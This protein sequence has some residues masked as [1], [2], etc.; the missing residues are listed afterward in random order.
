MN[1]LSKRQKLGYLFS[2]LLILFFVFFPKPESLNPK[3]WKVAFIA[4]L[5]ANFWITETIPIPITAL[6]PLGFFPILGVAN[7]EE[8][9]RGFS[10]PL[11]FLFLGG[12]FLALAIEKWN[13]HKRI[14]LNVLNF[15][16]TS[17]NK[18]VY[19]FFTSTSIISMWV[20]NTSTAMMMLPIGLSITQFME[21]KNVFH[22]EKSKHHFIT[23]VLLSIAYG[24]SIG[25]I[26]TLIGTAPNI[27]MAGFV[28]QNLNIEINFLSWLKIGIPFFLF[29]LPTVPFLLLQIFP[30]SKNINSTFEKNFIRGEL[31][32]L[33]SWSLAEKYI[34]VV[35]STVVVL[36]ISQP[37]WKDMFPVVS[38][39]SVSILGALVLF[40][41]P[42][43]LST[44]KFV[45][46]WQ[47][48]KHLPWDALLLFGGGLSLATQIESSQLAKWIGVQLIFFKGLPTFLLVFFVVIAIIFLTELTSNLATT[49]TFLPV[50]TTLAQTLGEDP[51]NF[52]IPAVMAAS[53]AFMLPVATP[54]N[55]IVY[56]SGKLKIQDM[57]KMGLILN[58]VFIFFIPIVFFIF[59]NLM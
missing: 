55:T 21:E 12:F 10:N 45:L 28:K 37:I 19:G 14:A 29:S 43:K 9:A 51:L 58:L 16:G 30:V 42:V 40:F 8:S 5:M 44:G 34:V 46:D 48:T 41:L 50:L 35:F 38:D 32:K 3:G 15:I 49:A 22:T 39:A 31:Q 13:L 20:N 53:C 7:I 23:C 2:I 25:G 17:P 27:F 4:C 52:I 54:P 47:A 59:K 24:A 6:F 57:N 56:A 33:G 26:C 11:I 18:L 1:S 36:W